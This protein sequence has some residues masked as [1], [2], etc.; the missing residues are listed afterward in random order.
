MQ[1]FSLLPLI[2]GQGHYPQ[3]Y[4]FLEE[5]DGAYAVRTP[6]WK[7]VEKPRGP[8]LNLQPQIR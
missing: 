1:G 3:P 4:V 6:D 8:S 7:E 5:G 2:R